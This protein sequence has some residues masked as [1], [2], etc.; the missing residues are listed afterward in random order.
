MKTVSIDVKTFDPFN[1]LFTL[2]VYNYIAWDFGARLSVVIGSL[3]AALFSFYFTCF[4]GGWGGVARAW[5]N[6]NLTGKF[7]PYSNW[8]HR[9]C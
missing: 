4:S 7:K 1:I 3:S 5:K 6:K 2:S 8:I 9:A